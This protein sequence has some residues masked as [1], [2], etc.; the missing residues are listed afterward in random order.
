MAA[1]WE[2]LLELAVWRLQRSVRR[3]KSPGD[4]GSDGGLIG[5]KIKEREAVE[6]ARRS[7]VGDCRGGARARR[8]CG[9][10]G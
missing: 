8:G 3:N 10:R 6:A 9:L 7:M 2:S 4:R 1:P 5:P